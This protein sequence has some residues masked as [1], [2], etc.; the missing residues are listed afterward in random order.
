MSTFNG[1]KYLQAQIE[2]IINQVGVQVDLFV[3]DD[4]STDSTLS[5]LN[6]Y[7][8]AK[9]LTYYSGENLK[10]AKSFLQLV[11]DAPEYDYYAFSDQDDVWM[12]NKMKRAV[13]LLNKEKTINRKPVI[14]AG[15]YLLV[16]QN[17]NKLHVDSTHFTTNNFKN[18]IVASNCTGCTMVFNNKL[19]NIIKNVPVPQQILMHDDWI[20][21]VCLAMGGKVIFDLKPMIMYRQHSN[22]VDGGVHTLSQKIKKVLN[23]RKYAKRLMSTQLREILAL[24]Y[25]ELPN[26]NRNLIKSVVSRANSSLIN[27]MGLAFDKQLLIKE[28]HNLNHNFQVA[29]LLNYW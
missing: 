9:K 15:S 10:S 6:K 3:R 20:H 17:L 29:L 14:Y 19:R 1:E 23:D 28:N 13:D 24:Y 21:K 8:D 2:S 16:D 5:I 26:Y 12:E 27:R 22:N 18:A 25:D 11:H 4:G 7:Q